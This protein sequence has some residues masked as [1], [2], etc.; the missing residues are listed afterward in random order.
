MLVLVGVGP[1]KIKMNNLKTIKNKKG[2]F[3]LIAAIIIIGIL[4]GFTAITNEAKRENIDKSKLYSLFAEINLDETKV[5]A[6]DKD[7]ID[8][9][10]DTFVKVYPADKIYIVI[11]SNEETLI[12]ENGDVSSTANLGY[13]FELEND[14]YVMIVVEGENQYV[15]RG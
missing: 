4:L 15:A 1:Y 5:T 7:Y 14:E 13:D 3:Y 12:Y 6:P 11:N 9:Q 10:L 8:T 2:Q